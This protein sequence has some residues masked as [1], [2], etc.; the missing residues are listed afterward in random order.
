MLATEYAEYYDIEAQ[1][2]GESDM[3][4]RSRVAARLRGKSKIIEAHEAY[5]DERYENSDSVMTGVTGAIAQALRGCSY[6][7]DQIGNDIAA[8]VVAQ[9]P[10]DSM[11]PMTALLMTLF[12]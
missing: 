7:G 10:E 1:Q 2:E 11:T 9:A 3:A 5:Q 12:S 8:G 6:S 4:F